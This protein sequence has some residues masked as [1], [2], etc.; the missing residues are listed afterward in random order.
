MQRKKT[1]SAPL[2]A[3]LLASGIVATQTR[4][5]N[6]AY[7]CVLEVGRSANLRQTSVRPITCPAVQ[8]RVAYWVIDQG[9]PIRQQISAWSINVAVANLTSSDQNRNNN[10][11]RGAANTLPGTTPTIWKS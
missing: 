8:A 3:T 11:G 10:L 1:F 5:V 4:V 9:S 7:D 2:A 6:A